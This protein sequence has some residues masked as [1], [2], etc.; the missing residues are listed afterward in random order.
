MLLIPRSGYA[1]CGFKN[2]AIIFQSAIPSFLFRFCFGTLAGS[3]FIRDS[4]SRISNFQSQSLSQDFLWRDCAPHGASDAFAGVLAKR[5]HPLAKL[6]SG[7]HGTTPCH[8]PS[9]AFAAATRATARARECALDAAPSTAAKFPAHAAASPVIRHS[10]HTPT[11]LLTHD[12]S[13]R[14]RDDAPA[15]LR[16]YEQ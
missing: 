13:E 8:V 15:R 9:E 14:A 16:Q 1:N 10:H 5:A 7:A 3:G 2:K 6:F 4:K 12:R 11:V